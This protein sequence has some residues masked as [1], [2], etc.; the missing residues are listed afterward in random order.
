M[1]DAAVHR[2][3]I[4]YPAQALASLDPGFQLLDNISD[5]RPGCYEYWPIRRFVLEQ[6]LDGGVWLRL[7]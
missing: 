5:E 7:A 2:H 4:A 3:Q 1:S 6:P